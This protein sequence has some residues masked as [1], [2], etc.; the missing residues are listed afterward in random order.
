MANIRE[1]LFAF[2]RNRQTNVTTASIAADMWRMRK[3]NLDIETADLQTEDD[4]NELG[5]GN[6]FA[7]NVYKVNW[8]FTGAIEKFLSSQW[9]AWVMAFSLDGG[10]KAGV[11]DPF[12]YT[13]EPQDPVATDSIELPYFTVAHQVRPGGSP[14]TAIVDRSDFGC[15]VGGWQ[16]DVLS[17]PGRA[18]A[19]LRADIVGTGQFTSPSTI[20]MPAETT[21]TFLSSA[22]LALT[23]NGINYVTTKKIQSLNATWANNPRLDRR[24][25]PGS[26]IQSGA[27]IGGRVEFGDRVATLKIMADMD[28]NSTEIA[29]QIAQS[30]FTAVLSLDA[31]VGDSLTLTYH[32]LR[33]ATAKIR[34]SNGILTIEGDCNVLWHPSNGL[35]TAVAV[36][37]T[38]EICETP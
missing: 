16:L 38:D 9:A 29:T 33:F 23:A 36:T 18:S 12:T 37:D 19:K 32:R 31:G 4:A 11:A 20:V 8:D 15:M 13:C 1:T 3:I 35:F 34:E 30:D 10:S 26:G 6:E 21:E 22:S 7:A 14:S 5:G 28:V 25:Y 24:F 2:S 27:A 17:G